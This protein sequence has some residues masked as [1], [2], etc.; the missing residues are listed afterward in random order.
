MNKNYSNISDN[1][2][3]PVG[4]ELEGACEHTDIDELNDT[5]IYYHE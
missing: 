2:Y 3:E 5:P 4:D 1:Y